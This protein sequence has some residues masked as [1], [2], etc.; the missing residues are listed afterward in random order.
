[1]PG[2]WVQMTPGG[3]EVTSYQ[4]P[5]TEEELLEIDRMSANQEDCDHEQ[6]EDPD[7]DGYGWER[8]ALRGIW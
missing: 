3:I 5:A 8:K 1:M 6:W 4:S 7:S 2:P